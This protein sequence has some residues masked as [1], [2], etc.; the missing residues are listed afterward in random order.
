MSPAAALDF[1]L[2]TSYS[3]K[4][5]KISVKYILVRDGNQEV[6]ACLK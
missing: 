5:L 1:H 4:D 2:V 3:N 6:T